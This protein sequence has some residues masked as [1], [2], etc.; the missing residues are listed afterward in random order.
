MYHWDHAVGA[1]ISKFPTK[2]QRIIGQHC[3]KDWANCPTIL[4]FF[5]LRFGLAVLEWKLH[6]LFSDQCIFSHTSPRRRIL[7]WHLPNI[8]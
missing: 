5:W 6:S 3:E 7:D 4:E 8:L 1:M 2:P